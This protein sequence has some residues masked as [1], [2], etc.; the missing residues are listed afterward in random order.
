MACI[1]I[2]LKMRPAVI[3]AETSICGVGRWKTN[4][5]ATDMAAPAKL[6]GSHFR[7]AMFKFPI[8]LLRRM[9]T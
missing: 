5:T 8:R 3:A 1:A 2:P 9:N 4:P 7:S 6:Y